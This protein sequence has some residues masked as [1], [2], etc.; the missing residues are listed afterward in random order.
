[1][2]YIRAYLYTP[3]SAILSF[4]NNW[5]HVSAKKIPIVH[6]SC[7]RFLQH[8][9]PWSECEQTITH[10]KK[11]HG[12]GITVFPDC[13]VLTEINWNHLHGWDLNPSHIIAFSTLS[14]RMVEL[15]L[16]AGASCT[17][18]PFSANL[19]KWPQNQWQLGSATRTREGLILHAMHVAVSQDKG[20][21][22][23][24][25]RNIFGVSASLRPRNWR[26]T[27]PSPKSN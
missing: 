5:S 13:Q 1:M 20:R 7:S 14:E 18:R 10:M 3:T 17:V 6:F 25:I 24:Y 2:F 15:L 16:S 27:L 26:F 23:D 4:I 11:Q 9:I 8:L 19:I 21:Q 22:D 12:K